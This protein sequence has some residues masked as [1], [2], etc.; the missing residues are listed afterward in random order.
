MLTLARIG[1]FFGDHKL[2]TENLAKAETLI[3]SGGDWDRRNRLKVYKSIEMLSTRKFTEAAPLLLD[4]L[5]TFTA[6]EV[7]EYDKLVELAIVVGVLV[8][9]RPDVKKRV[10]LSNDL[11]FKISDVSNKLLNSPDTLALLS[12]LPTLRTLVNSL[13]SLQYSA[14]FTSLAEL[15]SNFLLT[16]K[17]LSPHARY[18]VRE[19][20]I[21]A[22]RQLLESYRSVTL[23]RVARTFG[24]TV[25]W[26]DKYVPLHCYLGHG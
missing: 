7:V 25:E 23:E 1:F 9:E 21:K 3:E 15:E 20:R 26:V 4:A 16:S 8:L 13:Y 12:S 17:L 14:L 18:Y 22:Y 6:N 24:V 19:L 10:R 2:T 5:S 11:L